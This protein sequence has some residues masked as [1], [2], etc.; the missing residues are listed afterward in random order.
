MRGIT[1]ERLM[2]LKEQFEE[3][4]KI[5]SSP[6]H[7]EG[8]LDMLGIVIDECKEPNQWQTI[9]ENTPQIELLLWSKEHGKYVGHHG[10]LDIFKLG[11]THWQ[12]L[13]EDPKE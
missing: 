10:T 3:V 5:N 1:E 12:E 6:L 13:P 2:E 7:I 9:D 8:M 4:A 11:F